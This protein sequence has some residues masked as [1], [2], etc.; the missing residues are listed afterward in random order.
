M[1]ISN[2]FK[3]GRHFLQIPGPTN[4]PD[5]VLRAMDYPIIDHRGLKFSN[6]TKSILDRIKMVFKT[7]EPVVISPPLI[8]AIGTLFN[9]AQIETGY[10]SHR[11]PIM[12]IKS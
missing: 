12:I 3:S 10:N 8:C 4:I 2:T 6:L 11:S 9:V 1:T 5:R 7:K